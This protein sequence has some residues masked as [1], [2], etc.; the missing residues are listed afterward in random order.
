MTKQGQCCGGLDGLHWVDRGK[1]GTT[2][3]GMGR[4]GHR[5]R[6]FKVG[7]KRKDKKNNVANT[8]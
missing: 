8:V 1:P 7:G 6:D 3:D 5:K 4:D 2:R